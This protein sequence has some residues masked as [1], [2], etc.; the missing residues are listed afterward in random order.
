[1]QWANIHDDAG[2]MTDYIYNEGSGDVG[3]GYTFNGGL[4]IGG[5]T[6]S[7]LRPVPIFTK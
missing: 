7:L 3:K 1:M 5:S 4:T 2:N 6:S